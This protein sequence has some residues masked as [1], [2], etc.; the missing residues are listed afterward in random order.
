MGSDIQPSQV[1]EGGKGR[2]EQKKEDKQ[3]PS[4]RH[5]RATAAGK[6]PDLSWSICLCFFPPLTKRRRSEATKL[7]CLPEMHSAF[8]DYK[9]LL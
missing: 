3:A 9:P 6:E 2:E 1:S 4:L 7:G 8:A 5:T